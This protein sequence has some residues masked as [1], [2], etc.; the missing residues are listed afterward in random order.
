GEH[1]AARLGK[2]RGA[3]RERVIFFVKGD[4][5]RFVD[6]PT[7][8]IVNADVIPVGPPRGDVVLIHELLDRVALRARD[9]RGA[10]VDGDAEILVG[11]SAAP[12]SIARFEHGDLKTTRLEVPRCGEPR[13]ARAD[14][15]DGTLSAVC[16]VF[17]WPL[18]A[19]RVNG[20]VTTPTRSE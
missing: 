16:H 19:V 11:P 18:H 20:R 8:D 14:H 1:F 9:P 4:E 3:L 13:S 7:A 12:D 5:L 17:L 2:A 15:N 6:L 10:E